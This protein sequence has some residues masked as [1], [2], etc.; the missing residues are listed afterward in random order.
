ML[1]D[2]LHEARGTLAGVVI[3]PPA[4]VSFYRC[5]MP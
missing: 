3:N 4:F 1:I 2:W 5:S